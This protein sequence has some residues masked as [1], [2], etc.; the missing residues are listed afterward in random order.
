V[1]VVWVD[2]SHGWG[3][4]FGGRG[5]NLKDQGGEGGEQFLRFYL[6]CDFMCFVTASGD[7]TVTMYGK[8]VEDLLVP[9]PNPVRLPPPPL[10]GW[11]TRT[12][13]P[14]RDTLSG[15]PRA[16]EVWRMPENFDFQNCYC[17]SRYACYW[18]IEPVFH[19]HTQGTYV[20]I[21]DQQ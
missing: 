9:Y 8:G 1:G 21:V 19:S 2:G 10:E 15:Q 4:F 12:E 7:G 13:M 20:C 11:K 18:C 17:D 5:G 3:T 16:P 6:F 14:F